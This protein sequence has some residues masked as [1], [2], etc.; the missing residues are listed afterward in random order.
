MSQA[1]FEDDDNPEDKVVDQE[2]DEIQLEVIANSAVDLIENI[3][4]D[5]SKENHGVDFH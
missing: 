1:K 4:D 3:H 5:E 2:V